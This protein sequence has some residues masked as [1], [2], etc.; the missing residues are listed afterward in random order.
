MPPVFEVTM[1]PLSLSKA[2]ARA[3]GDEYRTTVVCADNNEAARLARYNVS[4][5]PQASY[6]I[7]NIKEVEHE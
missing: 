2:G 4:M 7:T 3:G 5:L 1:K 6:A